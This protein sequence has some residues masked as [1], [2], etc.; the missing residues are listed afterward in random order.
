MSQHAYDLYTRCRHRQNSRNGERNNERSNDK[1]DKQ[2]KQNE[3][4]LTTVAASH[5]NGSRSDVHDI[6]RSPVVE[7]KVL[8]QHHMISNQVPHILP[9]LPPEINELEAMLSPYQES[10]SRVSTLTN[11]V[12][13]GTMSFGEC[14]KLGGKGH[15]LAARTDGI[16][17]LSAV[18]RLPQEGDISNLMART[19]DQTVSP[20]VLTDPYTVEARDDKMDSSCTVSDLEEEQDEAR[21]TLASSCSSLT[22]VSTSDSTENESDL[23]GEDFLKE[24]EEEQTCRSISIRSLERSPYTRPSTGSVGRDIAIVGGLLFS[25]DGYEE[26]HDILKRCQ[27]V[28]DLLRPT[29]HGGIRQHKENVTSSNR[30]GGRLTLSTESEIEL[31][32]EDYTREI[33]FVAVPKRRSRLISSSDPGAASGGGTVDTLGLK[34]LSASSAATHPSVAQM[35]PN[36]PLVGRVYEGDFI[37]KV[38]GVDAAGF[39]VEKLERLLINQGD[40]DEEFLGGI[41]SKDRSHHLSYQMINLT[42]M[43]SK[44]DWGRDDIGSSSDDDS[45]DMG[46]PESGVE[47]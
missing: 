26:D 40:G 38:A 30:H 2:S 33:Y 16:T 25:G 23:H 46:V 11:S 15:Q 4:S 41:D 27:D 9:P 19:K 6:Y 37:L 43:S 1:D 42:V 5:S 22:D 13:E 24:E 10:L 7:E 21:E 36:S 32:G 18:H 17:E 35:L 12:V 14:Q 31:Y 39:S 28:E 3:G 45:F 20:A 29:E 34:L 8:V 47:L 44:C